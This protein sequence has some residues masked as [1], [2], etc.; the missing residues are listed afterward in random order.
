MLGVTPPLRHVAWCLT[1][2]PLLN[3]GVYGPAVLLLRVLSSGVWRLKSFE[4]QTTCLNDFCLLRV[5][6]LLYLFIIP[7][8]VGC[9]LLRNVG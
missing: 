4:S 3:R 9:T 8:D 5:G 7:E 6:L 1:F 2:L